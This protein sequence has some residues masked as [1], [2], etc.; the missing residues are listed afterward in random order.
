MIDTILSVV[1]VLL[2]LFSAYAVVMCVWVARQA[3][4]VE[5]EFWNIRQNNERVTAQAGKETNDGKDGR[6]H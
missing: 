2:L 6:H 5:E 3:S 4:K 1:G